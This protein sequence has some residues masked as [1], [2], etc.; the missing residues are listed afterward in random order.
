MKVN[1]HYIRK[2]IEKAGKKRIIIVLSVCTLIIIG[3]IGLKI[4]RSSATEDSITY[5]KTEV[6][7]GDI[8][9]SINSSG[10]LEASK[11]AEIKV[12]SDATVETVVVSEGD[13]VEK[14][15]ILMEL[16]SDTQ[17]TDLEIQRLNYKVA[18]NELQDLKDTQSSLKVYAPVSGNVKLS[19]DSIGDTLNSNSTFAEITNGNK[20]EIKAPVNP[21]VINSISVGDAAQVLLTG[22]YQ[23]IPGIVTDVGTT[24]KPYSEGALYY[25]VTV[26]IENPGALTESD[27]GTITIKNGKGNFTAIDTASLS[28]KA[29]STIRFDTSAQLDKLHISDGDY[30]KKGDLIAEFSSESLETQIQNQEIAVTQKQLQYTQELEKSILQSPISGTVL[31]VNFQEGDSIESNDTA[32]VISDIDILQVVVPVDE[33]DIQNIYEGQTAVVTTQAYPDTEFKAEVIKVGLEGTAS[34]GVSTFDVTLSLLTSEGLKPGMNVNA[35]IIIDSSKNSLLL[36]VEAVSQ[37]RG[38]YIAMKQNSEEPVQLKVG[39]ISDTYVEILDGLSE[40]DI[41]KYAAKL[42]TSEDNQRGGMMMMP[43]GP[44]GGGNRNSGGPR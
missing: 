7:R 38:E 40:G 14:D 10:T 39:L 33:Y 12:A 3:S 2:K 26:E 43:G 36:P 30:V 9:V 35:D 44:P 11:R 5:L 34:S 28:S 22:Y 31:S 29:G 41:V 23:S 25:E 24:A 21:A 13:R 18:L 8:N 27:T 17:D 1:F 19:F 16:S 4:T 6:I 32:F 15:D 20:M 42:G 37:M